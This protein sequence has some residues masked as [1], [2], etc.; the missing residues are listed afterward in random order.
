MLL[1]NL[2]SGIA[3]ALTNLRVLI[4]RAEEINPD[5]LDALI[6]GQSS[7]TSV[8][9][10]GEEIFMMEMEPNIEIISI[11]Q[12][13]YTGSYDLDYEPVYPIKT[14]FVTIESSETFTKIYHHLS[15]PLPV[16]VPFV[17]TVLIISH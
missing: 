1:A 5:D 7:T 2:I 6:I 16:A 3:T 13:V 17:F 11:S 14:N 8:L 4:T 9:D 12:P 15:E 10:E